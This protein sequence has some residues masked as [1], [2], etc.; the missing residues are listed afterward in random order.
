M[1]HK[2]LCYYYA[3]RMHH[4][5]LCYYYA[6]KHWCCPKHEVNNKVFPDKS[7]SMAIP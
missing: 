5:I 4:K 2:I 3:T 6:T 1:H 7:I